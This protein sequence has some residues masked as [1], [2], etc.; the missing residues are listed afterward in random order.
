M[1]KQKLHKILETPG[2][3]N[4]QLSKGL[5]LDKSTT[6]WHIKNLRDDRIIYS[7]TEGKYREYFVNPALKAVLLKW[8]NV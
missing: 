1:R 2:I 6:H 8:L 3:T 7:E 5:H 4:Q